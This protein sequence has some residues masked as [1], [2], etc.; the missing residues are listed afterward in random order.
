LRA[1]GVDHVDL[2]S[3]DVEGSELVVLE[4]MDWSIPVH[5]VI[6]ELAERDPEKDEKCRV[7]L[8]KQ[9]FEYVGFVRSERLQWSDEIWVN[10][11]YDYEADAES[12][13]KIDA[14][15]LRTIF[16]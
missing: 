7:I 2:F 8:R 1:V 15:A 11:L 5:V 10:R 13:F 14:S 9:G 16:R 12:H 6:I 4:T 3:I